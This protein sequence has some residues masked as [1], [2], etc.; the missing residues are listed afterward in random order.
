MLLEQCAF[1]SQSLQQQRLVV[2]GVEVEI[3]IVGQDENDVWSF[4][5]GVSGCHPWDTQPQIDPADVNKSLHRAGRA[6][7]TP[8][9]SDSV[10][11]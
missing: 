4:G 8:G 7:F 3:L 11:T 6:G 10:Q 1:I 9:S 5:G 2:E